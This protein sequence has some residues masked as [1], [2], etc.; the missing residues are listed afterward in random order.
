MLGVII[1]MITTPNAM[2][3]IANWI[4]FIILFY[5]IYNEM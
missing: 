4:I 5:I 2:A 3:L 1:N